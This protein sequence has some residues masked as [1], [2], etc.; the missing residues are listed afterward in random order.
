MFNM[1]VNATCNTICLVPSIISDMHISMERLYKAAEALQG[2]K[3]QAELARA[4]N[5]SSQTVNNWEA[6]GISKTGMLKAQAAIGCSATW[7]ETGEGPMTMGAAPT[8]VAPAESPF[9][10][11]GGDLPEAR[12]V[13]EGVEPG[14]VA[15][16]RVK[17]RLRAGVASFDT[18]PDM[19]GDGYEHIP[20]EV[21]TALRLNPKNLLGLR[22]RGFS[23]EPMLFE[24]DVVII[25]T[26]DTKP[27]SRELYAV[28]FN[29]EGCVK[30]LVYQGGQ[31]F[32]RSLH[33]E[34]GP[35]NVKSGKCSIVGRV[36]YQPGRVVTGRL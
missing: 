27:I 12:M 14:M 36:V 26:S 19:N 1:T 17:L 25:D 11:A 30:Q 18:E 23:M 5:Q 7:L 33:H 28:N 10:E 31:W 8:L 2:I 22:I 15:V 20:T 24:D 29:G 32:L 9:I 21:L 3:S 4:L 16:P 6:R 35:V 13:R 34:Y